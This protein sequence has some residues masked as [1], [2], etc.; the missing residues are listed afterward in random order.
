LRKAA[1]I[2]ACAVILVV[3]GYVSWRRFWEVR[4]PRSEK[5]MLAVLPFENLTGDPS[6]EYLADGLTEEMISQLGRLNPEQLG[7][8]GRTSVMGYKHKEERLDQIGRDL[9]VQY[10]LENSLRTSG[11]HMRVTSQLLQVKDQS[12]VWSH[13]YDYDAQDILT[14]QDDVAKAVAREI[15][16]RL[17][18]QQQAELARPHGVNP[19]AF[20]AYLQGH[21]YFERDSDT[22]TDMAAKYYERATQL[23]PSYALAWVGLSRARNWQAELGHIPMEEGR[24]LAREADERALALDPD[25]AAAHSQM[26]RLKRFED[27]DWAG[28]DTSDQRA[29]ALDPGNPENVRSAAFS[30]AQSGRSDE[31]LALASRAIKLDPLNAGSWEMLGEVEYYKGQFA[32]A[33]ADVKKAL[34]LSPDVF[35]SPIT[36]SKIYVMEGRPQDALAEIERVRADGVRAFLYGVAYS[37]LGQEKQ[38]DAALKEL[39]TKYSTRDAYYAAS[40]YAFRN[41]RDEAFEWL[42][43]AYA[44]REGNI[45]NTNLEPLLKNLHGDPRYAA[46]LK[47]LNLPN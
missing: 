16:L 41:Q 7:V 29:I 22:D 2:G 11:D 27:L 37:A 10:V 32:A 3:V 40:V 15:Q 47:K 6:R 5:V 1:V 38:S 23:D 30:A 34:E 8:I 4:P 43:R 36:L 9:A 28:A 42:D 39:V 26:G 35:F 20:D 44:Q 31:A 25:L 46:L 24:R 21:Y 19:Q 33:E 14:L 12:H 13:D 18:P 17:S 45:A